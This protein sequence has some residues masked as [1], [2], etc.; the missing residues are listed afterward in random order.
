MR[1]TE[2][3]EGHAWWKEP[4][5][6]YRSVC[7]Y[8]KL[9]PPACPGT[10]CKY[11]YI[12]I[13]GVYC[14][15][16]VALH[17]E[18]VEFLVGTPNTNSPLSPHCLV[19]INILQQQATTHVEV[20]PYSSDPYIVKLIPY[21]LVFNRQIFWPAHCPVQSRSSL[22]YT[23]RQ[24]YINNHK[25]GGLKCASSFR[26]WTG[27]LTKITV[28]TNTYSNSNTI[29]YSHVEIKH[30]HNKSRQSVQPMTSEFCLN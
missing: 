14:K 9:P 23:H 17:G 1:L 24:H 4:G 15:G 30:G 26:S 6:S 20:Y 3:H 16:F 13:L 7:S 25:Y 10:T 2:G 5:H 29:N 22:C 18:A 21:Q 19:L 28:Y 27:Q 12:F 8:R 11:I